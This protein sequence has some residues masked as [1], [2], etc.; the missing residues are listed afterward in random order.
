LP[1]AVLAAG[2]SPRSAS[3]SVS[4]SLCDIT[5][6][7]AI[8]FAAGQAASPLAASLAREVLKAMF[9]NKLRI[10]ATTLLILAGVAAGA[11][12]L[13]HSL[14]G[15]DEP[16][17]QPANREP[18]VAAR[19]SDTTQRPAPGRMFVLGRVLDPQGKPVPNSMM[20]VYAASKAQRSDD[21]Y[22]PM[23]PSPIGHALSDSSGRFQVEAPRTTSSR[24]HQFG[25]IALAPG[26][27]AGWV[28]LD[29]DA[30]RPVAD[31]TLR[32]EQLIEGR[33]FDLNGQPARDV[34]V[35]VQMMGRAVQ[36]KRGD[37]IHQYAEGPYF[38]RKHQD[39][40]PAWPKSATTD[41]QGRF[42]LRGVG[43]DVRIFLNTYDLRFARQS[44]PIDTDASAK[45]KSVTMALE[46]AKIITGRITDG[47]TGKPIPHAQLDI[48]SHKGNGATFN[49]FEADAEGRYRANPLSADLYSVTISAP[50]GQP[51]LGAFARPIQWPKG[52]V[53]HRL[54]MTLRRG[55]VIRGKVTEE[56]SHLPIAD[57]RLSFPAHRTQVDKTHAWSRNASTETAADGS[58]QFAV[59]PQ[60]GTLVVQGPSEDYVL[61]EMGERMLLD[62]KPGGRRAYAHAFLACDPKP[63]S[64]SLEV[65]VVLRRGIKLEGRIV[66]PDGRPIQTAT[67]ISRLL[68]PPASGRE[69]WWNW[70]PSDNDSSVKSGRFEV[71]GLDPETEVPIHFLEPK[72]KLGAT[73][74]FSGKSAI[75]G[76]VTVRLEPCGSAR[77]RFLTPE[78]KPLM[79]LLSS[80]LIGIN[81]VVTPG[82][83]RGS[84]S[85]AQLLTI[86]ASL[87]R[88]G[89]DPINYENGPSSDNQG[90][91]T[92][93]VLIPG[94]TY[95]IYGRTAGGR[96]LRK[97]FTVKP[98]ETLDIGDIVIEKPQQ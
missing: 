26:Y 53:E 18:P 9:L 88:G 7:A 42:T 57:A 61:S 80:R 14:A 68:L 97:E 94:A 1:A 44:I 69:G 84:E 47:D 54:D 40:L 77:A 28:D 37:T 55:V 15:Q 20:M 10:F 4:S 29:P 87:D 66:G 51:Y 52:A 93:P 67:M 75:G 31:I 21:P 92:F 45:S 85:A 11:G 73:V 46:P 90:R 17:R 79:G 22:A 82:P 71:H 32:P 58:F 41:A 64:Q 59:L 35:F 62:G 48:L 39:N 96:P 23:N 70:Q 27:G 38:F 8:Q 95:R 33:L 43:R 86:E 72:L 49:E 74:R 5:T 63:G 30:D 19:P 13:T 98:G 2:L 36:M 3:A 89:I 25:A 76:P 56:G 60:P 78:G 6:R 50:E 16:M 12:Y 34:T 24:H 81:I 65:D 83:F 91:I